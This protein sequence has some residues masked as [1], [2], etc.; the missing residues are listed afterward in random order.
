MTAI[1][2]EATFC[3]IVH[4]GERFALAVLNE[5]RLPPD[6][7]VEAWIG[8]NEAER[9]EVSAVKRLC[10]VKRNTTLEIH[11]VAK[12]LHDVSLGSRRCCIH[13]YRMHV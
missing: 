7:Q 4:A 6:A 1:D 3:A 13:P 8:Y 10:S 9:L 11:R 5:S 12:S 2:E